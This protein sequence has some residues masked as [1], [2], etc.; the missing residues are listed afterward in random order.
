[1]ILHLQSK[2]NL[3]ISLKA[4]RMLQVENLIIADDVKSRVF[5]AVVG[6]CKSVV[7]SQDLFSPVFTGLPAYE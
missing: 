2:S 5:L 6:S 4:S 7:V 3:A 1:M